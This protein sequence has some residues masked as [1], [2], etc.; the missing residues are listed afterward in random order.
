MH[1]PFWQYLNQPLWDSNRPPIFNPVEY[2]QHYWRVHLNRCFHNSFLEH[3]WVTDYQQFVV[4]YHDFCDRDPREEDP[5]WLAERC[6]QSDVN[7]RAYEHPENCISEP[8]C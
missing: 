5:Y 7:F 1:F 6:W 2:G 3:C 8:E 4:Y